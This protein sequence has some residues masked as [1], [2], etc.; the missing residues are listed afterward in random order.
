[1]KSWHLLVLCLDG[2]GRTRLPAS[3]RFQVRPILTEKFVNANGAKKS[4]S[5]K[6]YGLNRAKFSRRGNLTLKSYS[7]SWG[8]RSSSS[9]IGDSE[10]GLLVQPVCFV[11]IVIPFWTFFCFVSIFFFFFY[12]VVSWCVFLLCISVSVSLLHFQMIRSLRCDRRPQDTC[13]DVRLDC[14]VSFEWR[15]FVENARMVSKWC[16]KKKTGSHFFSSS[17]LHPCLHDSRRRLTRRIHNLSPNF[18][19][20]V[21]V[22]ITLFCLLDVSNRRD[23]RHAWINVMKS[24]KETQKIQTCLPARISGQLHRYDFYFWFT[25]HTHTQNK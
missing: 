11:V 20:Y 1:M 23:S 7:H 9:Y 4:V 6:G 15:P 5:G 22:Y 19:C 13:Q 25:K 3:F 16:R 12:R 10:T 14:L 21:S 2:K 8:T 24:P 17:S 18:N